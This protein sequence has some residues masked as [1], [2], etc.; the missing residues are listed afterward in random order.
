M[1]TVLAITRKE[2]EQ[3]F[4]S[5]IAYVVIALLMLIAGVFFYIYLGVYQQ[6]AAASMQ[7]GGE[8]MELS[9]AIMRPF[10]ANA[11]FFF[12]I[13]MPMLTMRL[14]AEEKKQGTYEL[15][16]TSPVSITQLV[17]GKYL[18][19]I[20][21]VLIILALLGLYPLLLV[22]FGG[23]PDVGPVLTGFLGLFLIGAAFLGVGLFASSVTQSQVIAMCLSFAFLIIFWII[24][25]VTR[26]EAWYGKVAQYVSIYQRFDDFTKGILNLN[27]VLYYL[28]FV[29]VS[30]FITG[31]VLQS[32][33][34]KS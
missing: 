2:L 5:P 28:S 31:I 30:L 20:S 25:W 12:L 15:L 19:V 18:G 4:A 1:R 24:N 9:Q 8:G 14:F 7:Y 33:R 17:V 6:Q 22:M 23:H 13:F 10:F 27:D 21:F 29:F 11:A 32:Q 3:Y 26:S 16:M 34:W